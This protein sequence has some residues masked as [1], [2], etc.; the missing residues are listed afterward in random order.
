MISERCN[1][2]IIISAELLGQRVNLFMCSG[3][4]PN[5]FHLSIIALFF[6]SVSPK[7]SRA[8]TCRFFQIFPFLRTLTASAAGTT[9]LFLFYFFHYLFTPTVAVLSLTRRHKFS[10][11]HATSVCYPHF[12]EKDP[13]HSKT[14]HL[15]SV[16]C[17]LRDHLPC[18]HLISS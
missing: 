12:A 6:L 18:F 13:R 10:L 3:E 9:N 4:G 15:S 14:C 1:R 2:S 5:V 8:D 17:M 16:C 7:V 11:C